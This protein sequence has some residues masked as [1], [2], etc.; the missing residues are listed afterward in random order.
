MKHETNKM[1]PASN[2]W[3]REHGEVM[4]LSILIMAGM[5]AAAMAVGLVIFN[6]IRL[7]RQTPDSVNAL[8]A[9]DTGMECLLY[10][11]F[12][13]GNGC[14]AVCDSSSVSMLNGTQFRASVVSCGAT[15]TARSIGISREVRRSLEVNIQQ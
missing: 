9:A 5:M 7:A 4:L 14:S 1:I 12:V 6:E 13:L 10:R 8:A 11:Y 3:V 15:T 2:F